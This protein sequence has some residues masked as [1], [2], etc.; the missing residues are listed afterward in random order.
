M[1]NTKDLKIG[2]KLFGLFKGEPGTGKTIGAAS[3]PAPYIFDLDS[4]LA[5]VR[6]RFPEKDIVFDSYFNNFIGMMKKFEELLNYNPYET[7]IV[8]SLTSF[9]RTVLSHMVKYRVG[10]DRT[11]KLQRGG[12]DVAQIEDYGGETAAI[13]QLIDALKV[14][15]GKCNIILIAHVVVSDAYNIKT[16]QVTTSRQL[17]TGGKKIAAEIPT[18]FNEAWHFSCRSDFNSRPQFMIN[19]QQ[20]GVDWAKTAL[21]IPYEID[22]TDKNLY[23]LIQSYLKTETK[24]ETKAG[25]F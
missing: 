9:A 19:T 20:T 5:P 11:K 10:E 18:A 24:T 14:L 4:R 21:P 2:D 3:F 15:G 6:L 1:A 12:L 13:V 22:W 16:Q 25:G 7:I 8:D 23:E 17:L